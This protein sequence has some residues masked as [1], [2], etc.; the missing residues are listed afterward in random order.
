MLPK[1]AVQM[2]P[3]YFDL[4]DC[5]RRIKKQ[6]GVTSLEGLGIDSEELVKSTG[7]VL[8]YLD[9]IQKVALNN[10]NS[11]KHYSI[12]SYMMLDVNTRRNLELVETI[13]GKTRKGALIS[14]LDKTSTSMGGRRLKAWIEK[15]LLNPEEINRDWIVYKSFI[16]NFC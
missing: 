6:F 4:S 3:S 15:P 16:M 11:I 1:E 13:R 9:E 8:L 5:D 10:I 7:A 2:Y 12:S 14:V